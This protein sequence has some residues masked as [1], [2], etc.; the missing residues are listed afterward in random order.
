MSRSEEEA[1][2]EEGNICDAPVNSASSEPVDQEADP[3]DPEDVELM[4]YTNEI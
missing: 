2:S 1:P 4:H 3:K